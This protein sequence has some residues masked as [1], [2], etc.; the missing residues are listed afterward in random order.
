MKLPE[1]W[2][3]ALLAEIDR[4]FEVTKKKGKWDDEAL[5]IDDTQIGVEFSI[6]FID[7]LLASAPTPTEQEDKPVAWVS[8]ASLMSERIDAE[9]GLNAALRDQHTWRGIKTDYHDTPLYTRPDSCRL[10]KAAEE[11]EE[12]ITQLAKD[13]GFETDDEYTVLDNLR[14]ALKEQK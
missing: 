10:R 14:A 13:V 4:R 3:E 5:L 9:R 11:A 12:L 7:A 8:D 2:K 1:G 6:D